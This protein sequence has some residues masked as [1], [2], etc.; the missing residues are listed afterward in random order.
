MRVLSPALGIG[1]GTSARVCCVTRSNDLCVNDPSQERMEWVNTASQADIGSDGELWSVSTDFK[2]EHFD[3]LSKTWLKTQRDAFMVSVASR[4]H[5]VYLD[6]RG[7]L[8]SLNAASLTQPN[9]LDYEFEPMV[10]PA[11]ACVATASDGAIWA[12][13]SDGHPCRYS[14][15][16]NTWYTF[17]ISAGWICTASATTVYILSSEGS[18]HQWSGHTDQHDSS[19]NWYAL[20]PDQFFTR[21]A[22]G[23]DRSLV[24]VDRSNGKVYRAEIDTSK[25]DIE[26]HRRASTL[27]GA[28]VSGQGVGMSPLEHFQQQQQQQ[29]GSGGTRTPARRKNRGGGYFSPQ[30]QSRTIRTGNSKTARRKSMKVSGVGGGVG[31]E[32]PGA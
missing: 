19:Q 9:P 14:N 16:S 2:L 25:G 15:S 27:V 21:V 13:T 31:G 1:A 20:L 3:Q 26:F 30:L 23:I 18:L 22:V 29:A 7:V 32:Q 8:Y 11:F 12:I 4:N 24:L 5:V 6:R 28:N 17:D 10:G